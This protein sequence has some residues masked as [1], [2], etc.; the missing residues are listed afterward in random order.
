MT[1]QDRNELY[2]RSLLGSIAGL[3]LLPTTMSGETLPT[4]DSATPGRTAAP[5]SFAW[6]WTDDLVDGPSSVQGL[7]SG[8]DGTIVCA[9]IETGETQHVLLRGLDSDGTAIWSETIA[10]Q[11]NDAALGVA[12]ESDG[13]VVFCGGTQSR[14]SSLIDTA[15]GR[16]E[17]PDTLTWFQSYGRSGTNDA[18]HA[19][20]QTRDG[21]HV[22]AGGTHYLGEGA[23]DGVGRLLAINSDGS[24]RWDE[25]YD[26]S[27]S[28]ELYD[29]VRTSGGGYAFAGTREAPGGGDEHVWLGAVDD[30][31]RLQWSETYGGAGS[32]TAYSVVE[33]HDGG[34][35]FAGTTEPPGAE[36]TA[37]VGKTD[38]SGT[39]EWEETY[40][41]GEA[42][43]AF[44]LEQLSEGYLVAGWTEENGYD[45][46]WLVHINSLGNIVSSDTYGGFGGDR[47]NAFSP[48]GDGYAAGGF[49]ADPGTE[50][51]GWAIGLGQMGTI[52]TIDETSI[53]I[54]PYPVPVGEQ[55]E[56]T[57]DIA[58]A[59]EAAVSYRYDGGS[60][61]IQLEE[62]GDGH[63]QSQTPLPTV[64]EAGTW[65]D[66]TITAENGDVEVSLANHGVA[67]T[68][69]TDHGNWLVE[70][71]NLGYYVFE[72]VVDVS[73]CFARFEDE[74]PIQE[75]TTVLESWQAA[76]MWDTNRFFGSGRGLKGAIGFRFNFFDNEGDGYQVGNR[77]SYD[78]IFTHPLRE[79][80]I[81]PELGL[82]PEIFGEC[83]SGNGLMEDLRDEFEAV[84]GKDPREG[85][86]LWI[87]T[88]TGRSVESGV[89]GLHLSNEAL[90]IGGWV[91]SPIEESDPRGVLFHYVRSLSIWLHELG[92]ACGLAHPS[93]HGN[94]EEKCLMTDNIGHLADR[95]DAG[96][97][98]NRIAGISPLSTVS[99]LPETFGIHTNGTVRSPEDLLAID[100]IEF[101]TLDDSWNRRRI[102]AVQRYATDD[103]VTVITYTRNRTGWGRNDEHKF[104]I[105]ARPHITDVEQDQGAA[106]DYD[107]EWGADTGG[108]AVYHWEENS[109]VGPGFSSRSYNVITDGDDPYLLSDATVLNEQVDWAE[110]TFLRFRVADTT[111]DGDSEAFAA[112]VEFRVET[113][114]PETNVCS[115]NDMVEIQQDSAADTYTGETMTRPSLD[116]KAVDDQG[117]TVGVNDSGEY[118]NEI[119]GATA[120]GRRTQ[121]TEW[122]SVPVDADVDFHVSA[123][124]VEQFID[125]LENRGAF[126]G[127][128][129][130]TIEAELRDTLVT[131]Y[132]ISITEYEE[133]PKLVERNG[134]IVVDGAT[135]RIDEREIEPGAENQIDISELELIREYQGRSANNGDNLNQNGG[136]RISPEQLVGITALS[137]AMLY[138][139]ARMRSDDKDDQYRPP[140]Q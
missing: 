104:V 100:E 74:D 124:A 6:E 122:I 34:F 10:G 134:D 107:I 64:S 116:L 98:K 128:E 12:V 18:G 29:V 130:A 78:C 19:I 4:I 112:N 9:G 123:A 93:D 15:V 91:Y 79:G 22:I 3:G 84:E 57:V 103:E 121:G 138:A 129:A 50:R 77:A 2:R 45:T 117:R 61:E 48:V 42:S 30:S 28:G 81:D 83:G 73:V 72:S 131:E 102:P 1:R 36:P 8:P 110:E 16:F 126:S 109:R 37:W 44:V 86:D 114:D 35:V 105:E 59:D 31:G 40:G 119:P 87:G 27:Y 21:G 67:S 69:A 5:L 127:S 106:N 71:D 24:E 23:G 39:L 49:T 41:T 132:G 66:L 68:S 32:R 101:E 133:D 53:E 47:F 125:E 96:I 75:E 38:S 25:T 55:P 52:P 135:T 46:G 43:G 13:T 7:T 58:N 118:V 88:H 20:T 65:V 80:G 63:W 14:G 33:A 90:G 92:H 82:P 111:G 136:I 115:L 26:T 99:L 56:I 120:S 89:G 97:S 139:A 62:T 140:P 11:G 113:G 70:D 60:N 54:D 51:T 17:P 95:L 85:Y 137:A 108:V 76:R 94:V